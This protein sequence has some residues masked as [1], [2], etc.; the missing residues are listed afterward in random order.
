MQWCPC[1]ALECPTI[2]LL[3]GGWITDNGG[4]EFEIVQAL[5]LRK[6]N[7]DERSES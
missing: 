3:E 2:A 7:V 5:A 4:F 6:M 1:D